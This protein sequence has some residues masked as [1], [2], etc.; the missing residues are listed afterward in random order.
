MATSSIF[1]NFTI[2]DRKQADKFADALE[3]SAKQTNHIFS[4]P[5]CRSVS[6]AQTIQRLMNCR[7]GQK[8]NV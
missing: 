4:A 3:V 2:T 7:K 6:D 8:K 1:T 5:D